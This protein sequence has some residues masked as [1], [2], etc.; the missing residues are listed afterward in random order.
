MKE[1]VLKCLIFASKRLDVSP[2]CR[3]F[4]SNND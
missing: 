4:V 3:I 2:E 1:N